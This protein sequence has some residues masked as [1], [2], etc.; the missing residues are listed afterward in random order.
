MA[1]LT[2]AL[3]EPT[4]VTDASNPHLA[5]DVDNY[6]VDYWP[7]HAFACDPV[8]AGPKA[9]NVPVDIAAWGCSGAFAAGYYDDYYNRIH[10]RPNPVALGNLLSEQVREVE[11][12]NAYETGQLLT[13]V[14]PTG[15]EG[16]TLTEPTAAPTT[17]GPLESR[18]YELAIST[19]GPSTIDA[20]YTFNFPADAPVLRVTGTRVVVW[21][22]RP[23]WVQPLTERLE[24]LTDVIES[25]DGTEQRM[26]LRGAPRR[27]FSFLITVSQ[28]DKRRLETLLWDWQARAFAVPVWTDPGRLAVAAKTDDTV[29]SLATDYLDYHDD[30]LAVLIGD[31]ATQEAL[32]IDTVS[33]GSITLAR[34]LLNDWPAGTRIYPAR[35]G[36]LQDSQDLSL[37]TATLESALVRF[38]IQDNSAVSAAEF[39]AATYRG[40]PVLETRPNWRDD[41]SQAYRRKLELF[42]NTTGIRAVD[43]L[44]ARPVTVQDYLWTRAG[45]AAI[46]AFRQWLYARAGKQTPIWVPTYQSD[47]VLAQDV[48]DTDTAIRVQ[49]IGYSRFIRQAIGRRD[50]A[51]R[52]ADGT[53]YYRRITASIEVDS[54][55]EQLS[56]DSALGQLVKTTEVRMISWLQLCRVESDALELQWHTP[57]LLECRHYFRGLNDDV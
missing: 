41:I 7:P 29:L 8:G 46:Y 3:V 25:D 37:Y 39:S 15:A 52:L 1:V 35:I 38:D 17:F 20:A 55:T 42:D 23:N 13:A 50:I 27:A 34:P 6:A 9:N 30:G 44:S 49:N 28:A 22:F 11:V 26:A 24:W 40:L 21:P 33:P 36:R 32:E 18:I 4:L 51:I 16:I 56:I 19:D 5:A 54:Q 14:T 12:W 45:R 43:D 31:T 47:L 53:V 2:G 48:Q 10:I 57:E